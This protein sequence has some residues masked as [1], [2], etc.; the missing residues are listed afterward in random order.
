MVVVPFCTR[1]TVALSEGSSPPANTQIPFDF[2]SSLTTPTRAMEASRS[3]PV[4]TGTLSS[5]WTP[6][7]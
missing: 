3:A 4:G 1:T 2:I 6:S 5:I 7:R